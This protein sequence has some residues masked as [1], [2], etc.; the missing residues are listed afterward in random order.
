[1]HSVTV[2]DAY[3]RKPYQVISA[4]SCVDYWIASCNKLAQ[5][6]T[7]LLHFDCNIQIGKRICVDIN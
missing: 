5:N 6:Y 7:Q 2:N 4:I 3:I 1:V